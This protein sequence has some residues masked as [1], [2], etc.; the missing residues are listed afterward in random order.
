M[1][2][3]EVRETSADDNGCGV[4]RVAMFLSDVETGRLLWSGNIMGE[5]KP[6]AEP[7]TPH[8]EEVLNSLMDK[9]V[10]NIGLIAG[11]LAGLI[12]LGI[13]VKAISRPR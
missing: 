13:F 5:Y 3:G 2:Y 12:A 6:P 11:V 9:A 1:L 7:E 10:D 4:T 8:S